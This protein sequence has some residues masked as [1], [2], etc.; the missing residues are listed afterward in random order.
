MA[1]YPTI[2]DVFRHAATGL[3][4]TDVT[5]NVVDVNKAFARIVDRSPAEMHNANLFGWTHPED[6]V[7]HGELLQQLLAAQI[8]G[9]VIEKRYLRSDGSV[10]WV[11][12]SVSLLSGEPSSPGHLIS[13]C[14]DISD[15]KRAEGI[16]KRQEQM[17]AVGR[18]T[19]SILHEINNPLE[20][21]GNLIF[22]ARQSNP[23]QAAD[24][25][26]QAE[27]ELAHASEITSQGLQFHRQSSAATST[28]VVELLRSVLALFAGRLKEAR[29]HVALAT[30]D[31]P[32][33]MCFPGEIRQVFVNLISNAIDSMAKGGQLKI[34]VRPGTD[35]RT[36]E[37]GVRVTIAD[38][39]Q[40]MSPETRK[41]IYQPFFTTKGSQGSG[42]GLWVTSNI[43]KKHQGCVH[44]RSRYATAS[45]GTAFS[46]IF[47]YRGAQGEVAGYRVPAA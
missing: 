22:L 47:P 11:R 8:P 23:A 2:N 12:N 24:Y 33:L 5:G 34:R 14:E 43:V 4:I 27:E 3:A 18:L 40:G 45:G 37:Q 25:L 42:L 44:V 38:T 17:A 20:A 26:K 1:E 16:L 36:G 28:N 35:W 6:Q 13:I 21:V 39:G 15:R 30:D 46:L 31:A 7:R 41:N 10:V 9:F 32:E 19:S 29:V